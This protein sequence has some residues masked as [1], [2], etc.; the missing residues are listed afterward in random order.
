[1]QAALSLDILFWLYGA[2]APDMFAF[3][4]AQKKRPH[5]VA[6]HWVDDHDLAIGRALYRADIARYLECRRTNYWPGVDGGQI[7]K[8]RMPGYAHRDVVPVYL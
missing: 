3:I 6:V 7:I 1:M 5:D 4:P 8:A 2:E